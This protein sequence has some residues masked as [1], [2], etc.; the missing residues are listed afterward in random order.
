MHLYE[1]PNMASLNIQISKNGF[2]CFV[3]ISKNETHI[4]VILL[5]GRT[6]EDILSIF[7]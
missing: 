5:Q 3:S 2:H 4:G 7:T 6:G 1:W